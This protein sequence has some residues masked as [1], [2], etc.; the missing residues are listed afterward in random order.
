MRRR[1]GEALARVLNHE[2]DQIESL[3]RRAHAPGVR[4]D[5]AMTSRNR[6]VLEDQIVGGVATDR[7]ILFM[8]RE[9]RILQWPGNTH[10]PRV[11]AGP[12]PATSAKV[13]DMWKNTY[14]LRK[15]AHGWR[16]VSSSVIYIK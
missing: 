6:R 5:R 15:T 2:V 1:E 14:R 10:Q 3:A 4:G 13:D 9:G 8:E 12:P 7:K 16:I 11:C